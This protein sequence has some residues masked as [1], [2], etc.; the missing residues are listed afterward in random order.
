M[1]KRPERSTVVGMLLPREL[2][3][4]ITIFYLVL[5]AAHLLYRLAIVGS[6][7]SSVLLDIRISYLDDPYGFTRLATIVFTPLLPIFA[8]YGADDKSRG[9]IDL[10]RM[11]SLYFAAA[12]HGF[13][14]GGRI[15]LAYPLASYLFSYP[16]SESSSADSAGSVLR[17]ALKKLAPLIAAGLL[18][19][20]V[21]DVTRRTEFA[22]DVSPLSERLAAAPQ[23]SG[24]MAP[25]TYTGVAL[26][27][28]DLTSQSANASAPLYGQMLFPWF[29]QQL[30]RRGLIHC[31]D[32]NWVINRDGIRE[33]D[34]R[35][36]STHRTVLCLAVGDFGF[37]AAPYAIGVLMGLC[38]FRAL[39]F[40]GKGM[41]RQILAATCVMAAA[42]TVQDTWFANSDQ[43]RSAFRPL[44]SWCCTSDGDI[45]SRRFRGRPQ[46]QAN[47]STFWGRKGQGIVSPNSTYILWL[48]PAVSEKV[49][50]CGARRS[51]PRQTAGRAAWCEH[52]V[53]LAKSVV[54]VG[55]VPEAACRPWPAAQFTAKR[56]GTRQNGRDNSSRIPTFPSFGACSL[57]VQYR[58]AVDAAWQGVWSSKSSD[59]LQRL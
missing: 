47:R 20:I 21:A 17:S 42:M 45:R 55:H 18:L 12:L 34:H 46:I 14:M 8:L 44:L 33:I 30:G 2:F 6:L 22:M 41:F 9:Q 48:G 31:Y 37:D 52:R 28:I 35:V 23:A 39:V 3:R 56:I 59:Q 5:G 29:A 26:A 27:A 19:F 50:D 53:N 1:A 16:A 40:V 11:L 36:A 57:Q 7:S 32:Q 51:V 43:M 58:R 15:W 25:V 4:T 49:E 10:K 38:Q 54:M 24:I 13:A